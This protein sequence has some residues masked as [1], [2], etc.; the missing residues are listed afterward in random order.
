MAT[1]KKISKM[2]FFRFIIQ[3]LFFITLP[4]LYANAF[5]GIK[6]VYQGLINGTFYFADDFTSLI[7]AIAIFP[8]TILLGRF[9]CGWMCAF[10]AM[11]D[12]LYTL[13]QKVFKIKV[14]ISPKVDNVLKYLKYVVLIAFFALIW[15]FDM[16]FLDSSN[17]WSVFGILTS[18]THITDLGSIITGFTFGVIIL[19]IIMIFSLFIER[20]FCRYLCPLGAIFTIISRFGLTKVR[21][22]KSNCGSCKLC[23]A[24]CSMG[25]NLDKY[26]IVKSGE[27]IHC[28]KCVSVCPKK[29]A[30]PSVFKK[31]LG[32]VYASV[33]AVLA[34]SSI[35]FTGNF[36]TNN[37]ATGTSFAAV[38]IKNTSGIGDYIDG[39][40]E[41]TGTGFRGQITVSVTV[42]DGLIKSIEMISNHDDPE[43][44]DRSFNAVT[45][46]IIYNQTPNVDAVSGATYSSNG[47]MEA[48]TN[49][50]K[51]AKQDAQTE[52]TTETTT[53]NT[54]VNNIETTIA[55]TNTTQTTTTQSNTAQTTTPQNNTQ[56]TTQATTQT[57]TTS[58]SLYADGTY[59][60]SG[61]GYKNRTTTLSVTISGGKITDIAVI[62]F[63]DDAP[64]FNN[65][66][67]SLKP[68]I[69]SAQS[70]AVNGVSGATFSSKGIKAAVA[71]ALSKATQ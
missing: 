5:F 2:Q 29:N 59:T 56:T 51:N 63:G 54:T 7:S 31:E 49:A 55:Q 4:G 70:T 41:G 64:Y 58:S 61:I 34:I 50:L 66:F 22:T 44:F 10:G 33:V 37:F 14:K 62:S 42:E 20:F 17:P 23:T 11:G 13:S 68:T 8:I 48:V 18:I 47:I 27:C 32:P 1:K 40:Y 43:Y 36:I 65:A 19:L 26:D 6:V 53:E 38:N 60:G 71:S 30:I 9:F 67:T 28:Y 21:K 25:I 15:I 39:V 16:S 57:A 24:K 35:Y 46:D 45:S 3:I 69:I 52:T 12:W